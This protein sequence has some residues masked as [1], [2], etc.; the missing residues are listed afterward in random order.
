M[1]LHQPNSTTTIHEHVVQLGEHR[2]LVAIAS[3]PPTPSNV[4]VM[5]LVNAGVIHRIGP[6]RLHVRLARCLAQAGHFAMR[7]DLSGIGDSGAV[8]DQFSFR[9]SS[10]ADIRIAI[11]HM[12]AN[13][14]AAPVIVFGI[15]SG[16]DNALAAAEADARIAGLVLVDPPCYPTSQARLRSLQARLRNPAAWGGLPAKILGRL[17]TRLST[18]QGKVRASSGGR[19]PPPIEDYRRQL[20]G[21]VGRDVRILSIYSAASGLRY[22]H[23]DQLFESF[24]EL[25]GKLDSVYCPDANH[26]FTGIAQQTALISMVM[27]WCQRRFATGV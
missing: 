13:D 10:V 19:Q 26:T 3:V 18:P 1:P 22:N 14:P 25:R 21:L 20:T 24:P 2:T 7:M 17:R 15:C 12:S 16:A 9:A 23:A 8:P 4:P 11:D 27:N 6:H 5:L